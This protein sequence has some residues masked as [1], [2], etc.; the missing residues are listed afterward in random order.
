[1]ISASF[2]NALVPSIP[3]WGWVLIFAIPITFVNSIGIDIATKL[4]SVLVLLMIIAVIAFVSSASHYIITGD[5]TLINFKAIYDSESFS[6]GAVIGGAA[7]VIVAYLGF[8]AI[9]TLAEE[10]NVGE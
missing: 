7:I 5:L 9:T 10:T 8:D 4:N 6:I 3:V 1:M 2:A